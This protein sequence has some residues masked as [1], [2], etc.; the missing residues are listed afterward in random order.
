LVTGGSDGRISIWDVASGQRRGDLRGHTG[1]VYDLAF[2]HDGSILVSGS[3]D[4]TVRFWDVANKQQRLPELKDFRNS[5]Y[6]IALNSDDSVLATGSCGLGDVN[7][8][9]EQGEIRLFDMQTRTLLGRP[10]TSHRDRVFT[11]AFSPDNRTLASGGLDTEI[12]LWNLDIDVW[13]RIACAIVS[14]NMTSDEW[15]Q[16]LG[17]EPQRRTCPGLS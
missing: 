10:L 4:K 6:S 2:T 11:L 1:A 14:R 17:G 13:Q 9:C 15:A 5:V 7:I 8:R 3:R 12:M 16:Y